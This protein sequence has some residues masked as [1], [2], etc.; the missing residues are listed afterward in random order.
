VRRSTA[1]AG[2]A[3]DSWRARAI[4][5]AAA[6]TF[7]LSPFGATSGVGA[8]DDFEVTVESV[9]D[10]SG[11]TAVVAHSDDGVNLRSDPS[12]DADILDTLPDGTVVDLRIDQVDTVLEDDIRWWPVSF[13]KQDGWIAGFYLDDSDGASSSSDDDS[14][15]DSSDFGAGDYAAARTDDGTSLNIRSGAG[16]DFERV[17]SVADGDVVQVMEGPSTDD[18]GDAWYL[19]T[20]GDVTGYVFADYLVGASQPDTPADEP[21][22][23]EVIFDVGDYVESADGDEVNIRH[24]GFVGSDVLGTIPGSGAVQIVGQATFDDEGAAWYKI[25]NGDIRGY[26]LGDLLTASDAPP[27]SDPSG[28]T[29]S[30]IYPLANFV[31]TQGYGCTGFSFEPYDSNLGCNFHNGIDIA[32][33]AY[34]PVLAADGGTVVAAGWCDCGLGYYVEIDHGNGFS[35]VYGHMAEQPY[36]FVGQ[37]VDQGD[38]IGPVG[39][40]G[41]STGPHV[42]FMIK[43]NGS[44]VNPLDYL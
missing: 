44:T 12:Q 32:A 38:T 22:Q 26:A 29:G 11:L 25:E 14:S 15:S 37:Q 8:Q 36:V 7:V 17:G 19:V 34:T 31:Q 40:T 13:D 5:V 24:R 39:S 23:Q 33:S 28:P 9:A 10:L 21:D 1:N 35:T 4:A 6:L 20:D 18:D 43:L 30:F 41:L 3:S 16:T 2:V 42:H 27:A